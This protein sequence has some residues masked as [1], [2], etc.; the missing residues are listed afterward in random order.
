[1]FDLHQAEAKFGELVSCIP[2]TNTD[3]KIG[4]SGQTTMSLQNTENDSE[5]KTDTQVMCPR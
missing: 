4:T 3:N 1:M 5:T 2:L